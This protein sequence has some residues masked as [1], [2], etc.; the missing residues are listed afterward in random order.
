MGKIYELIKS[1]F[2]MNIWL[3]NN[4]YSDIL[5]SLRIEYFL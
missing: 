3:I 5:K 4:Y 1:S 2:I